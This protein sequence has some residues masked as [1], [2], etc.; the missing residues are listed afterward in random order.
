LARL[1]LN[2]KPDSEPAIEPEANTKKA[3]ALKA[4]ILNFEL[5]ALPTVV[6]PH[7]VVSLVVSLLVG[8]ELRA[9]ICP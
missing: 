2:T 4:A 8:I 6:T 7:T 1:N 3:E 5:G 9:M